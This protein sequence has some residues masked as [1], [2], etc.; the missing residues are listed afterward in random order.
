[1][2]SYTVKC[3][4]GSGGGGGGGDPPSI[5]PLILDHPLQLELFNSVDLEGANIS[6][7][8]LYWDTKSSFPTQTT[9]HSTY[10]PQTG[11]ITLTQT[12]QYKIDLNIIY[13]VPNPTNGGDDAMSV[14]IIEGTLASPTDIL[15]QSIGTPTT[16]SA[17]DQMQSINHSVIYNNTTANTTIL[18]GYSAF[19][20]N[21]VTAGFQIMGSY[22]Q[23]FTYRPSNIQVDYIHETAQASVNVPYVAVPI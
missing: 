19:D 14:Y 20:D 6:I 8:T 18:V 4:C 7:D 22:N 11:E 16:I 2:T 23:A 15:F 10:N 21:P 13:Q 1:M 17:P 3:C 9:E 5:S 12:G